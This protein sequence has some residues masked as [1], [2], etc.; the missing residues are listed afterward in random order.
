LTRARQTARN[1]RVFCSTMHFG[2]EFRKVRKNVEN[3]YI[4]TNK[5]TFLYFLIQTCFPF[6]AYLLV[7]WM[8]YISNSSHSYSDGDSPLT[9]IS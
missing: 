2:L 8:W 4:C 7:L 9:Y 6:V 1:H 3:E 5:K